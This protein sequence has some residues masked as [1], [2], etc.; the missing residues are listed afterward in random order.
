M[1]RLGGWAT[2]VGLA[3][4]VSAAGL[5]IG[6]PEWEAARAAAALAGAGCLLFALY[7]NFA[8]VRAFFARR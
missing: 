8:D 3:L 5:A 2:I 6:K 1:K 7:A 4:L